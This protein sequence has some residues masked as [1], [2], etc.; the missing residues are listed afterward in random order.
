M[1]T[2]KK[3]TRSN[4]NGGSNCVEIMITDNQILVRDTKDNGQGAELSFTPAEWQAF[5]EGVKDSEF[6]L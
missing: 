4:G 2:W 5:I 6:D 3:S 1:N